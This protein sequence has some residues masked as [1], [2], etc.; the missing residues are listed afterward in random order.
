MRKDKNQGIKL[1]ADKAIRQAK[2]L[3]I[4]TST[5]QIKTDKHTKQNFP[6]NMEYNTKLKTTAKEET[7]QKGQL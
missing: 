1:N 4:S 5:S 6:N 7:R 3:Q 2:P